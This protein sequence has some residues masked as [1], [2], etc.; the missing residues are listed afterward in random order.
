MANRGSD[1]PRTGL[2]HADW[3][4]PPRRPSNA[5][6]VPQGSRGIR[7]QFNGKVVLEPRQLKPQPIARQPRVQISTTRHCD[8]VTSLRGQKVAEN[9]S[10]TVRACFPA[11]CRGG[12]LLVRLVCDTVR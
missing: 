10:T 6:T 3:L 12:V 11:A 1:R 8:K 4:R 9:R 7:V 2:R 5:A